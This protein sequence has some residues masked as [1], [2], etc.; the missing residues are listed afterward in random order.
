LPLKTPV[1]LFTEEDTGKVTALE[2]IGIS[3][4]LTELGVKATS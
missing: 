4:L 3:K 2:V 1:T